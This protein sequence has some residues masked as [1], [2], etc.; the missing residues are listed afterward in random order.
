MFS[1]EYPMLTERLALRPLD[2][3]G[4]VDAMHAYQSRADVCR[5]IP[6]APRTREEV[7]DVLGSAR[8][9]SVFETPGHVMSLAVVLRGTDTLIGDVILVWSSEEHRRGEIGYVFN[10]DHRGHG[11]ATETCSALLDFAIL[12]DEWRSRP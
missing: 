1:P 12:A 8:T 4:D 10:P 3:V 2:P 5:Y 7:A 11:Y 6:Y 9:R